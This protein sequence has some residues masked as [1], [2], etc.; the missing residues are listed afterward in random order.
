MRDRI[1]LKHSRLFNSLSSDKQ[2]RLVKLGTFRTCAPDTV[3][4]RTGERAK[5]VYIIVAGRIGVF[6]SAKDSRATVVAVFKPGD[7]MAATPALLETRYRFAGKALDEARLLAI[8]IAA[9]R[10]H[11]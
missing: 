2:A 7:M 4:W 11:L 6:A 8:P 1:G 10:R 9:Y 5:F 3:R